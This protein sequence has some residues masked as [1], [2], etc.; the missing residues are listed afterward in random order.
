[1]PVG[2]DDQ[3]PRAPE[4]A[5]H[6]ECPGTP[7]YARSAMADDTQRTTSGTTAKK[8]YTPPKGRPT[9][10]RDDDGRRR[11]AFGPVAQ[12]IT[13]IIAAL[14]LVALIIIITNGGDYNPYNNDGAPA[15]SRLATTLAAT[16]A[17]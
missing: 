16:V 4:D 5:R 9:R 8:G 10:A 3:T 2:G 11:R 17:A 6:L 1:M 13:L 14:V 7:D 15:P 12:W